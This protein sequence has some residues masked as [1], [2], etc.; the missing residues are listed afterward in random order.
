MFT[1][2]HIVYSDYSDNFTYFTHS[3]I[4]SKFH[5][6]TT[7]LNWN[8]PD[9]SLLSI[10]LSTESS[11]RKHSDFNC[12]AMEIKLKN[13]GSLCWHNFRFQRLIEMLSVTKSECFLFED[14]VS[15][16]YFI[17]TQ[18]YHHIEIFSL[19]AVVFSYSTAFTA[20]DIFSSFCSHILTNMIFE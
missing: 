2:T 7:F 18:K 6:T 17:L 13:C 16:P 9:F 12:H 5:H 19:N 20:A 10:I 4:Q 8:R 3:L 14:S 15:Q 11:K 1:C